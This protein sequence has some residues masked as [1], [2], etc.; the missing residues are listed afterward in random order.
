MTDWEIWNEPNLIGFW[1]PPNATIYGALLKAS[2]LAIKRVSPQ[3]R[4]ISGGL[5]PAPDTWASI[6]P[7]TFVG[8]L[9]PTGAL[10]V[11]DGIGM[12]PYS[13]PWWVN[14]PVDANPF[15][16]MVPQ[17]YAVMAANGAGSLK[18][19]AT[20]TGWPTSSASP[21]TKRAD[22]TQVGTEADQAQQLPL[23]VRTWF[24]NSYAGPLFVYEERDECSNNANWLC[25]MGI[26]RLDGS[27]KPGYLASK[28]A[29]RTQIGA[30]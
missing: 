7:A 3:S 19:W 8:E 23:L 25:K 28:L 5:A 15:Y 11:I 10:S 12:H 22:G 4:V 24:S 2:A 20:E 30:H 27:H 21:R 6:A 13:F 26:E 29:L 16:A 9:A 14:E 17:L 1:N 18:I